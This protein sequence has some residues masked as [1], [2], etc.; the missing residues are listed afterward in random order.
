MNVTRFVSA[1]CLIALLSAC[2]QGASPT[3][4]PATA[5]DQAAAT[6][7]SLTVDGSGY[8]PSTLSAPAGRPVRL[9][10]TRT[11]DDGCGQQIAFPA[12]DIRRDL[13]LN[14]V[15]EIQFTMPAS[16]NIAFACGMDMWRGSIV[17]Q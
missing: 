17:A 14:R 15:V 10:I 2:E 9:L 7:L 4:A 3:P 1:T 6:T 16:G 8:H 12:L 5:A 11:S 13:P